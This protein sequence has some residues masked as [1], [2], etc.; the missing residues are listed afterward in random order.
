MKIDDSTG[1]AAPQMDNS[2]D[3]INDYED[4]NHHM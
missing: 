3:G 2:Y 1:E 4:T